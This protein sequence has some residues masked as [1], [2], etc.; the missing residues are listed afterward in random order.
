MAGHDTTIRILTWNTL[1]SGEGG[2]FSNGWGCPLE[3][4]RRDE[5]ARVLNTTT[6]T[7]TYDT[8]NNNNDD[9]DWF[10]TK[11]EEL[12]TR[13]RHERLRA[14][15]KK[16][17]AK[18][19]DNDNPAA[20]FWLFQEVTDGDAWDDDL[21]SNYLGYNRVPC[22]SEILA[23][24]ETGTTLRRV[25]VR[26]G[27]G[28]SHIRSVPLSSSDAL[29]GGCLAEFELELDLDESNSTNADDENEG[30]A[31]APR[32]SLALVNLHGKSRNMRDPVLRREGMNRMWEQVG[33]HLRSSSSNNNSND[34]DDDGRSWQ[35][36]VVLCGDWNTQLTNLVGDLR[37]AM[38]GK[39]NGNSN[40]NG[41][42]H[43]SD[44]SGGSG[45][46]VWEPVVG[47]LDNAT[48][49]ETGYP[50][51]ST[52]HEDGFLAQYDGCLF[53]RKNTINPNVN[54]K[55]ISGSAGGV[56]LE[57]ELEL[58]A[59]SWNPEGFMPKGHNGRLTGDF[60]YHPGGSSSNS[61]SSND[62][63][64]EEGVY[65]DGRLLPGSKPS[66]GLSD[67]LRIYT[68]IRVRRH[69]DQLQQHGNSTTHYDHLDAKKHQQQL[70]LQLQQRRPRR[71][72]SNRGNDNEAGNDDKGDF[73]GLDEADDSS[74]SSSN[75][76][77]DDDDKHIPKK[78]GLRG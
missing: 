10:Q 63:D 78:K 6:A 40:G 12:L 30:T 49:T 68:D 21:N 5:L 8:D 52:N 56:E 31:A 46:V 4:R 15:M 43:D 17:A 34:H 9:D 62:Q 47:L 51:F 22:P 13:E 59:T 16:E 69:G 35:Q 24:G 48:A 65:L 60:R 14:A 23:S 45:E 19:N 66:Q 75:H 41:D 36:R 42:D 38:G 25:Y 77:D 74:S 73:G 1:E 57:L 70:Q 61:N 27:A 11:A 37:A 2:A 39:G 29:L 71:H 26:N 72:Y 64:A 54:S 55:P 76:N 53:V 58:E 20:D 28:W 18:H 3:I 33:A 50:L 67:H 7:T 44:A 32:P